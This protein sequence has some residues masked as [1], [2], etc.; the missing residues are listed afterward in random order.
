MTSSL[1]GPTGCSCSTGSSTPSTWAARQGTA[2]AVVFLDLDQVKPINDRF[3]HRAGDAVLVEAA[4]RI[5]AAL[6]DG[7]TA[8]RLAGDEF[9][10]VCEDL[11]RYPAGAAHQQLRAVVDRILAS[12]T[13]PVLVGSAEVVV[14]V[15]VGAPIADDHSTPSRPP[16]R[17]R[18]RDGSSQDRQ[19]GPFR[20]GGPQTRTR[21]SS[22]TLRWT[23]G[24]GFTGP[25]Q[26]RRPGAR[27]G[28]AGPR[29]GTAPTVRGWV[30]TAATRTRWPPNR[31]P[32]ARPAGGP[33]HPRPRRR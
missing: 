6:R 26:D 29:R 13:A 1:G 8:T 12:L 20:A 21:L 28:A 23:R 11:P 10:I 4:H 7:D 17:R 33:D 19:P 16:P 14:S 18:H 2:V 31:G 27:R 3:G 5:T 25:T 24:A 32:S 9:V 30:R 15:S 22:S